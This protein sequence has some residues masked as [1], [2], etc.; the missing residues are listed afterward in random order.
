MKKHDEGYTLP[1]V[2][3]ILMILY[4][5]V[6]AVLSSAEATVTA[7][8]KS[9]AQMKQK[10]AAQGKIEML[11]GQ[12]CDE[13]AFAVAK[14]QETDAEIISDYFSTK[15]INICNSINGSE[16]NAKEKISPLMKDE[17]VNADY[18]QKAG[19]SKFTYTFTVTS[20]YHSVQIESKMTLTGIISKKGEGKPLS[21]TT[22]LMSEPA[23]YARKDN[24][25]EGVMDGWYG[26]TENQII[27]YMGTVDKE[28]ASRITDITYENNGVFKDGQPFGAVSADGKTFTQIYGGR[29]VEFILQ[30]DYSITDLSV[31]YNTYQIGDDAT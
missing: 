6:V 23:I 5:V 12:L 26:F 31:T 11:V 7:Q 24:G 16:E 30:Q 25:T 22:K 13:T 28:T 10:Y 9:I 2:L 18:K 19:S 29:N 21:E 20:V 14:E 27:C 8:Q 1:Y 3:V 15:I 17:A 4:F